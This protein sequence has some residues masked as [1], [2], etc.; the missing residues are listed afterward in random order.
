MSR[1]SSRDLPTATAPWFAMKAAFPGAES[2]ADVGGKLLGAG[3]GV[4][5]YAD[6]A[7]DVHHHL[8]DD[9][10]KVDAQHGED[11]GVHGVGVNN[12]VSVGSGAV[13]ADVQEAFGG[14]G[15]LSL[16]RIDV[17]VGYHDFIGGHAG[18][19]YSGR[20]YGHEVFA[21][22]PRDTGADVASRADD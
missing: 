20:G 10:G 7:A 12:G 17:E 1:A 16:D 13:D 15:K 2:R 14:R 19:W 21:G 9:G 4:V 8:V 18:V 22:V 3:E 5:G 6:L 11:A